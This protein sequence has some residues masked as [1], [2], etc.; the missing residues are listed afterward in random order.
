MRPWARV[1]LSDIS[2]SG[3]RIAWFPAVDVNRPLRIK[4]PG[5]QLLSA[6]IRW[7]SDNALGCEFDEPLHIAVFEH[8]V[9]T[10]SGQHR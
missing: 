8:I 7:R 9:R 1:R 6:T 10:A 5:M 4:I 2:Q 3:F